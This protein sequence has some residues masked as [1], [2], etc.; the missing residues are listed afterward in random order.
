[1]REKK[2]RLD[3][4]DLEEVEEEKIVIRIYCIFKNLFLKKNVPWFLQ[5]LST[6]LPYDS[7]IIP[8]SLYSKN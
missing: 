2:S 8:L 3:G 7:K 1:M 6:E 4:K 5:N